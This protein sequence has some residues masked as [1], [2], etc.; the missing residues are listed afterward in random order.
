M[1]YVSYVIHFYAILKE[2]VLLLMTEKKS[3][4]VVF[5]VGKELKKVRDK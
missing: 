4:F 2:W 5:F 3:G 1:C